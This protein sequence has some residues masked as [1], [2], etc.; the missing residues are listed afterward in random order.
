LNINKNWV[1]FVK[2]LAI[3]NYKKIKN[4][5]LKIKIGIS[6]CKFAYTDLKIGWHGYINISSLI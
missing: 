2:K 6:Y 5:L 3:M 1:I 4:G